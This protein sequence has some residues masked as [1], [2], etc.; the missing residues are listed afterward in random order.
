VI[1]SS[2]DEESEEL[3]DDDDDEEDED[4]D[5]LFTFSTLILSFVLPL[6]I[7]VRTKFTLDF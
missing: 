1:S 4:D 6:S 3:S 2:D 5:Y 7:K